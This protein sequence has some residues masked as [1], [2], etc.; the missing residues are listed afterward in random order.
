MKRSRWLL[1][2]SID[3]QR[4]LRCSKTPELYICLA[5][6]IFFRSRLY[7]NVFDEC[8]YYH[9][10]QLSCIDYR[11]A[12]PDPGRGRQNFADS[13]FNSGLSGRLRTTAILASTPQSCPLPIGP[14][15][16]ETAVFDHRVTGPTLGW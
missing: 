6:L 10:V 7:S 11:S 14:S 8:N 15:A 4:E 3:Y 12:T 5:T 2:L 1:I 9:L 16:T 13:S